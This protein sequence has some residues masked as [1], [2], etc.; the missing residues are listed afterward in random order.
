MN[1]MEAAYVGI[2]NYRARLEIKARG[3]D[4]SLRTK[5][6]LYTFNKPQWIRPDFESSHPGM[7]LLYPDRNGKALVSPS[8]WALFFGFGL[9]SDNFLL[10][11]SPEQRIDQ[12]DLGLLI[13]NIAHSLTDRRRGQVEVEREDGYI[14]LRVLAD[15]HFR[16]GIVTGYQFV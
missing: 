10:E 7:V 4:G 15:D 2:D 1:K 12:I 14:R 8:G 16:E 13:R 11:V 6:L 3:R 5:K 9:A